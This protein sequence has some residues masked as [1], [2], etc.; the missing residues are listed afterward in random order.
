MLPVEIWALIASYHASSLGPLLLAIPGLN[1]YLRETNM[2]R[3][4]SPFIRGFVTKVYYAKHRRPVHVIKGS[5]D[6]IWLKHGRYETYGYSR[7]YAFGKRHG[8]VIDL[9]TKLPIMKWKHGKCEWES[10]CDGVVFLPNGVLV[11]NPWRFYPV[12]RT[13]WL[14]EWM[15][16]DTWPRDNLAFLRRF[17][18]WEGGVNIRIEHNIEIRNNRCVITWTPRRILL[19][20]CFGAFGVLFNVTDNIMTLIEHTTNFRLLSIQS[21]VKKGRNI[22]V[23]GD[24]IFSLREHG[25]DSRDA[26]FKSEFSEVH[27]RQRG[28]RTVFT[29]VGINGLLRQTIYEGNELVEMFTHQH[30]HYRE[31]DLGLVGM[32]AQ[33][34]KCPEAA[35]MKLHTN[36]TST[37][38]IIRNKLDF[39]SIVRKRG[40]PKFIQEE[41]VSINKRLRG[42]SGQCYF[43]DGEKVN[44]SADFEL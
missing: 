31:L 5:P 10:N 38:R 42:R 41:V 22:R 15:K 32:E 28:T 8:L 35:S 44:V 4:N 12:G 3:P 11:P 2:L 36:Y 43:I 13:V 20:K 21:V 34:A 7:S 33:S 24:S 25:P 37:T 9:D 27:I 40:M 29:E 19:E 1:K 18:I 30:E 14:G 23:T 17:T 39:I 6:K 26:R 16:I